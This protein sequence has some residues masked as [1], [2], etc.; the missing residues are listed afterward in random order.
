MY[1]S[2]LGSRPLCTSGP[3]TTSA[4]QL[5]SCR[6]LR[7]KS[8]LL[9]LPSDSTTLGLQKRSYTRGI[10]L[11]HYSYIPTRTPAKE[12]LKICRSWTRHAT[13]S[14]RTKTIFGNLYRAQMRRM[15]SGL[16]SI[17]VSCL[18]SVIWRHPYHLGSVQISKDETDGVKSMTWYTDTSELDNMYR[19][20]LEVEIFWFW[21]RNSILIE[22]LFFIHLIK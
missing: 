1:R 11:W 14:W 2:P 4:F 15:M 12:R 8:R 5:T 13:L 17:S 6:F 16:L 10:V 21:K 18:P 22:F 20:S 7:V 19:S 9:R 3:R